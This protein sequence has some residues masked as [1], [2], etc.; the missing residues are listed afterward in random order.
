MILANT[1]DSGGQ[2]TRFVL[3]AKRYGS[4]M[5]ALVIQDGQ[6]IAG[7]GARW[8]ITALAATVGQ[9][10]AG[11]SAR[12]AEASKDF[13]GLT[14]RAA[15]RQQTYLDYPYD[16]LWTP[17]A[18]KEIRRLA[19]EA[20]V[21]HL[22]DR[23]WS[24]TY[25]KLQL[26]GKP[27][28]LHHHGSAFRGQSKVL[29]AEARKY[30]MIEAVSTVDLLRFGGDNLTW[31]PAP[32]NLEMLAEI[33]AGNRRKE[34][35]RIRIV[36]T[37]T[38]RVVKS[39]VKLEAA[40]K[41]L[42]DEGIPVDLVVGEKIPWRMALPLKASADIAFDQVGLGYGCSAIE[43]WGMG[44]PVIAGGDAWTEA[45]ML[46]EYGSKDLPFYKAEDTIEGIYNSVKALVLSQDL[47]D[48]YA[49][50][51]MAHAIKFHDEKVALGRLLELYVRAIE[52]VKHL[53]QPQ[54]IRSSNVA[55]GHGIRFYCE[56]YPALTVHFAGFRFKFIG[57]YLEVD[58][59]A[60]V[61]VR[62]FMSKRTMYGIVEMGAEAAPA[63]EV[64]PVEI[65]VLAEAVDYASMNV[66][67]LQALLK[68]R[69]LPVHG[70][71]D[72]LIARLEA[73]A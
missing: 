58:T 51:G 54:K 62:D 37:P 55:S 52:E 18:E 40:V 8:A 17:Q 29:S 13:E 44:L 9:D 69:N 34:D 48:E 33:R 46:K 73:G 32:Y 53:P 14:I 2:N 61:L 3:A 21:I 23:T 31:L 63:E 45:R 59:S 11:I 1:W 65:P 49:A 22:N 71:K 25:F 10:T 43:A 66:L 42:Q 16:I 35:G 27:A 6:D 28:L 30:G 4:D 50:R 68:E 24:Y 41:A 64:V 56:R 47:R 7:L 38:N 67:Q 39:T 57:G 72:K 60:A 26:K 19:E 12:F 20:D 5:R 36:Q 70:R 15:H